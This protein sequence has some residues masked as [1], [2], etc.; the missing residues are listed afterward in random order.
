M[1]LINNLTLTRPM[2]SMSIKLQHFILI[3]EKN[4]HWLIPLHPEV[5][6]LRTDKHE[7]SLRNSASVIQRTLETNIDNV[8]AYNIEDWLNDDSIDETLNQLIHGTRL[9]GMDKLSVEGDIVMDVNIDTDTGKV[10]ID[11]NQN[12]SVPLKLQTYGLQSS[13]TTASRRKAL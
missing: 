2:T 10:H 9:W 13:Y 6:L 5:E 3:D 12:I 4:E 7:P 8:I 11:F 1:K